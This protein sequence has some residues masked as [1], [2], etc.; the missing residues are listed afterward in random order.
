MQRIPPALAFLLLLALLATPFASPLSPG[1]FS[2]T[3]MEV[4]IT[5]YPDGTAH[6]V[7]TM[8]LLMNNTQAVQLYQNT[9]QSNDLSTWVSQTGIGDLRVHVNPASVAVSNLQV[10]SQSPDNCNSIMG[11]CFA[12]LV[13]EYDIRPFSADKSGIVA[14][15]DYKPRTTRYTLMPAALLLPRSSSGDILLSTQATLRLILPTD[16]T[17]IR[18]SQ[19]PN[20]LL[21]ETSRFRYDPQQG[22]F[23]SER[24][25]TWT[26]QTLSKF[27]LIFDREAPLEGEILGYFSRMQA[28]VFQ[29]AFSWQGLALL[30]VAAILLVSVVWIHQMHLQ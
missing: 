1:S 6:G 11:I 7:E 18:F 5:V 9:M 26:D 22:Y 19:L 13:L 2:L 8:R 25:F 12:T 16:A 30:L 27:S 15:D 21:N 23:G 20:N 17:N 28:A 3:R 14:L 4:A 29:S 24:T 10:R